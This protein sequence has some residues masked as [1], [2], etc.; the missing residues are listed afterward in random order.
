MSKVNEEAELPEPY[1]G[2]TPKV[3]EVIQEWMM[4]IYKESNIVHHTARSVMEGVDRDF[5]HISTM[6]RIGSALTTLVASGKVKKRG[7]G[8]GSTDY[9]LTEVLKFNQETKERVIS[10]AVNHVMDVILD[11][12]P[13][14]DEL[15]RRQMTEESAKLDAAS[16]ARTE[17]LALDKKEKG[18]GKLFRAPGEPVLEG[19]GVKPIERVP[20]GPG[21]DL[22]K[23]GKRKPG[24]V[25]VGTIAGI[26]TIAGTV[27]SEHG[28]SEQ[29]VRLGYAPDVKPPVVV[30]RKATEE[31][32]KEM[33]RGKPRHADVEK[34]L[35]SMDNLTTV[36]HT[37]A[38]TLMALIGGMSED[39]AKA[40]QGL[41]VVDENSKEM[42]TA[43][44]AA[45]KSYKQC[46]ELIEV[47]IKDSDNNRKIVDEMIVELSKGITQY[48]EGYRCGVAD[49]FS[50]G[51]AEAV[52]SLKRNELPTEVAIVL[53]GTGPDEAFSRNRYVAN[54]SLSVPPS[55]PEPEPKVES[56][57][58]E[59][60]GQVMNCPEWARGQ[61]MAYLLVE[62]KGDLLLSAM[63][64]AHSKSICIHIPNVD[65]EFAVVNMTTNRDVKFEL[66][67]TPATYKVSN[68]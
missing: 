16:Q 1:Q 10:E 40:V 67:V 39:L 6:P 48:K 45:E 64:V 18:E 22:T 32:V 36:D 11:D 42:I 13:K 58:Y 63:V 21:L 2:K 57:T 29:F 19:D 50:M 34:E 4:A 24:N 28:T 66:E 38:S 55:K 30:M 56:A 65:V 25:T 52:E 7:T 47:S 37:N 35:N 44:K 62:C 53:D 9:A 33:G 8:R 20:E 46:G 59:G 12:G 27:F 49:G 15:F 17:R 51:L 5:G 14:G 3:G 61:L 43:L 68:R 60:L 31:E 26:G 23:S 54:G 41:Q